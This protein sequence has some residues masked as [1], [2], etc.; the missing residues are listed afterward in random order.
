MYPSV[1]GMGIVRAPTA[2]N[3]DITSLEQIKN[4]DEIFSDMVPVEEKGTVEEIMDD[5]P[6][7]AT[8][9]EPPFDFSHSDGLTFVNNESGDQSINHED[10]L[11]F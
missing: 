10:N 2:V 7:R 5:G 3:P 4:D 6:E 8:I 11:P 9:N 1:A